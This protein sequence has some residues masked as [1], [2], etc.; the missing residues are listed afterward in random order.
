MMKV[1]DLVGWKDE[2]S[3]LSPGFLIHSLFWGMDVDI[4]FFLALKR[5]V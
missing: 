2:R 5:N 3:D 4:C 1:G